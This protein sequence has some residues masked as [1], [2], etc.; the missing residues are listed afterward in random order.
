MTCLIFPPGPRL[1]VPDEAAPR[2]VAVAPAAAAEVAAQ[3]AGTQA[4]RA[5]SVASARRRVFLVTRT[6]L[7]YPTTNVTIQPIMCGQTA[8]GPSVTIRRSRGNRER[9]RLLTHLDRPA[10]PIGGGGDRRHRVRAEV[11]HVGCPAAGGDRDRDGTQADR[12]EL[13]NPVGCGDDRRHAARAAVDD[14][15]GLAVGS[16]RDG[17]GGSAKYPDRSAWLVGGRV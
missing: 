5:V 8:G 3:A 14:V 1:Q 16:D 7:H 17:A 15:R 10:W 9:P 2:A 4:A 12:N 11:D 6:T 13:L